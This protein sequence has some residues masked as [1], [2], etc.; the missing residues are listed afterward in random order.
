MDRNIGLDNAIHK[1]FLI[2][3]KIY[4]TLKHFYINDVYKIRA[5]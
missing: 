2:A 5:V 3:V 1:S 4:P